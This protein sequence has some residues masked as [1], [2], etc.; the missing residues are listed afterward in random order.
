MSA[1]AASSRSR[2]FATTSAGALARNDSLASLRC[3]CSASARAA[4]RSFSIRRR[5]AATSITPAVSSS[6]VTFSASTEVVG[7]NCG[8]GSLSRSSARMLP[9][10]PDRAPPASPVS[11][12]GTCCPG[13]SPWSERNR[14]TS[15]TSRITEA[16]SAS[17]AGSWAVR[18]AVPPRPRRRAAGPATARS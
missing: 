4:A 12:A 18:L 5:S 8:P 9:S 16:I 13:R 6:T 17:A 15:V 7:R 2:V 3:A 10:W 1:R 11:A 14:R